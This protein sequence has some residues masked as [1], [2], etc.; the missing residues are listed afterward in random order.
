ME[1]PDG[2]GA[3]NRLQ[4]SPQPLQSMPSTLSQYDGPFG[5][6]AQVPSEA[7]STIAQL[8]VQQ[9]SSWPHTSPGWMQYDALSLQC[10]L[11]SQRP[12]QQSAFWLHSLPLVRQL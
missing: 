1:T 11:S 5:G 6:A 2:P 3:H 12:E 7:P 4:Q 10:L 9:S 8:P